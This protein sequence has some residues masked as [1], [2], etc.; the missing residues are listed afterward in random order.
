MVVAIEYIEPT[1][2]GGVGVKHFAAI[3]FVE[4]ADAGASSLGERRDLG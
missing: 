1:R 4:Y 3:V 2:V